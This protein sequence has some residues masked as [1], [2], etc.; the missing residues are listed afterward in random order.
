MICRR[1]V[2]KQENINQTPRESKISRGVFDLL[3]VFYSSYIAILDLTPNS[4]QVGRKV[5]NSSLS[6]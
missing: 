6:E 2:D 1:S 3:Y 5:W 4:L